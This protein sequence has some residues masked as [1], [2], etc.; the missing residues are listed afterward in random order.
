[1][2]CVQ[3][4]IAMAIDT[5]KKVTE[6]LPHDTRPTPDTTD[7]NNVPRPKPILDRPAPANKPMF[8]N[9]INRP[10]TVTNPEFVPLYSISKLP[11]KSSFLSSLETFYKHFLIYFRTLNIL[12][13]SIL[14]FSLFF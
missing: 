8:H 10:T 14:N 4:S 3:T 13:I 12:L 7:T 6:D 9:V 1:M 11:M 5:P 2:W